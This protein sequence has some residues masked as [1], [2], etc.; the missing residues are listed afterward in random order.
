MTRAPHRRPG[1]R[2]NARSTRFR[3]ASNAV[4]EKS[5]S[6][7]TAALAKRRI[8]GPTGALAMIGDAATGARARIAAATSARGDPYFPRRFDPIA[9]AY[10]VVIIAGP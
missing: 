3:C 1:R 7:T 5:L 10:L 4:G 9:I 2:P 6:I 8:D